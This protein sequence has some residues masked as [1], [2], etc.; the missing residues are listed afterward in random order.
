MITTNISLLLGFELLASA[1]EGLPH[2]LVVLSLANCGLSSRAA[3]QLSSAMTKNT[4]FASSLNRSVWVVCGCHVV[5][6]V[7]PY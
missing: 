6:V 2:G 7:K 3:A 1:L 5:C 4:H